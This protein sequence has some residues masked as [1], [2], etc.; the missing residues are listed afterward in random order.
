MGFFWGG[1]VARRVEGRHVLF[2][3]VTGV[4]ILCFVLFGWKGVFFL[5]R[6]RGAP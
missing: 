6:R 3:N 5:R 1:R 4:E 2:K